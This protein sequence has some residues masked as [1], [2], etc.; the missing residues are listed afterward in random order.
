MP[1]IEQPLQLV[2]LSIDVNKYKKLLFFHLYLK[3][4]N[5]HKHAHKNLT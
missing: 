1:H 3:S 5:T 2:I 4:W